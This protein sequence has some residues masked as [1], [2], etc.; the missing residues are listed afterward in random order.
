MEYN[1]KTM[2]RKMQKE[3]LTDS[4]NMG[5]VNSKLLNERIEKMEN[6]KQ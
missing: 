3:K 1:N 6:L 2:I 5:A 4:V